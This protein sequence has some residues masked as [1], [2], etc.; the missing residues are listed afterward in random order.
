MVKWELIFFKEI[1]DQNLH[2][3]SKNITKTENKDCNHKILFNFK[4][5]SF[6]KK[7]IFEQ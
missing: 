7:K 3:F 2:Y 1:N 6:N 5:N 4:I